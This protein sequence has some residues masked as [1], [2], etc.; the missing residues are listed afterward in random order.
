MSDEKQVIETHYVH[1]VDSDRTRFRIDVLD[2]GQYADIVFEAKVYSIEAWDDFGCE[3]EP[4]LF[5]SIAIKWDSCAH[6]NYGYEND[7]QTPDGYIHHCG[8]ED[9]LMQAVL[10]K[11]LYELA[12]QTMGRRPQPGEEWPS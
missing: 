11:R 2:S 3:I 4:E 5:L 9:F 6:L 8:A 1:Y 10:M 12:F 7:E